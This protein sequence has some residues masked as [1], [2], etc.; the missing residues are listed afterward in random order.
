MASEAHKCTTRV[1]SW[2]AQLSSRHLPRGSLRRSLAT[3]AFWSLVGAVLSRGFVLL[4]S[5]VIARLLGKVGY[6]Q[7][8]L[9][10]SA[11]TMFAG[12]ASLGLGLTATKHIAELRKSDRLRA[13]RTLSLV[14]VISLISITAAAFM[15]LGASGWLAHS[16]YRVPELFLPLMLASVMLATM[17]AVQ[18]LHA[19]LAG[20]EDF[21]CIA[22]LSLIQ[23]LVLFLTA[24]PLAWWLGLTGVVI[25]M[26]ISQGVTVVLSL[27]ALWQRCGEHGMPLQLNGIWQER[28]ILW[29]YAIP[30]LLSTG[31]AGPV[32]ML[33][34][35]IVARVPGGLAG[36]GGFQVAVRWRDIVLF[37]P[38]AVQRVT[39]PILSRLKGQSDRQRFVRALWANIG[40]NGGVALAGGIP[41]IILSPWILALYG[42]GFRDD[43]D[44]MVVMV[45]AGVLRAVIRVLSQVTACMERMWWNFGSN[46]VWSAVLLTGTWLLVPRFGV[47]GYVWSWAAGNVC[48]IIVMAIAA[49]ILVRARHSGWR[50]HAVCS[51]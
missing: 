50:D 32:S 8:G 11:A 18:V 22:R 48:H 41:I 46:L 49:A 10:L 21:R 26:S 47:R 39:L 2:L 38:A 31:V 51:P 3:G 4:A 14:L 24:I 9:V 44:I 45:V 30:S 5:I 34:M 29:Q 36:L 16:L 37:I 13:G 15:C 1:R 7:W 35:A 19:A 40:L 12:L 6:G 43:W 33:S 25:G 20:F 28:R 17:V 42:R 27:R 23:G